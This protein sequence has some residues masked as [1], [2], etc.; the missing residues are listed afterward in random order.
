MGALFTYDSEGT[1]R[2]RRKCH[3]CTCAAP[4]SLYPRGG[5]RQGG[6]SHSVKSR[7]AMSSPFAI[8]P[9]NKKPRFPRAADGLFAGSVVFRSYV[10]ESTLTCVFILNVVSAA[11]MGTE[12]N[13]NRWG[14]WWKRASGSGQQ[15]T[16]RTTYRPEPRLDRSSP[17]PS[18]LV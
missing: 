17:V 16:D 9:S 18:I 13:E 6:R 12:R 15:A 14:A 2:K 11:R 3:A 8:P 1:R 5:G 4:C 10:P 7:H